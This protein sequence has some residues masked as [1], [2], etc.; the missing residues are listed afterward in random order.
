MFLICWCV[1]VSA[2]STPEEGV[3]ISPIRFDW[4]VESGD[5]KIDEIVVHNFS[6]ISHDVEVQVEDFFVSDDSMQAIFFVPADDHPR[7]AYDVIE[8]I[9]A[10]EDFTLAPGETKKLQFVVTIPEN[11]PTSG[12]YGTIFFKTKTDDASLIN[13]NDGKLYLSVL[14]VYK[15]GNLLFATSVKL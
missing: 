14:S 15:N 3:Q 2:E 7:K 11:Q 4:K 10:P 9:D 6:D 12:Y 5:Q 8:W 13:E 1:E